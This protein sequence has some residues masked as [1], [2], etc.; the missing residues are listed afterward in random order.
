MKKQTRITSKVLPASFLPNS[1]HSSDPPSQVGSPVP[2]AFL[3][4]DAI[5]PQPIEYLC[6]RGVPIHRYTYDALSDMGLGS[7][8][9]RYQIE[10]GSQRPP[11]TLIAKWQEPTEGPALASLLQALWQNGFA[12]ADTLCIAEPL[13]YIHD[14]HILLQAEARGVTLY[15]RLAALNERRAAEAD[16]AQAV[17]LAGRWLAKLHALRNPALRARSPVEGA[18]SS[19]CAMQR[20]CAELAAR[21][22]TEA[23]RITQIAQTILTCLTGSPV[24]PLVPTHGDFHPK[25]IYVAGERV[26]VIDFDRFAYSRPE[27][28]IGYFMAQS[29][30]MAYTASMH[31]R[32]SATWNAEFMDSY[33]VAGQT[34]DPAILG[35]HLGIA[36]LEVLFYRLIVRPVAD[37]AFFRDWLAQCERLISEPLHA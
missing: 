30:T 3:P 31:F 13:G 35:A 2:L 8:V 27:R 20:H 19:L 17:R 22:P 25:N 10:H 37:H 33:L 32:A 12:A 9:I 11:T 36:F 18:P 26:T 15:S 28:D 34:P 5:A 21:F 24:Q 16:T 4:L 23:V 14:R 6:R 7:P 1:G 29:M